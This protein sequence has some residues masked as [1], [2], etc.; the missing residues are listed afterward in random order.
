MDGKQFLKE[1]KEAYS[2][3]YKVN[4]ANFTVDEFK[5]SIYHYIGRDGTAINYLYSLLRQKT[6]E[7]DS[8][9]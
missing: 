1:A 2:E 5:R 7:L 3:H 9:S 4:F 8:S 6:R